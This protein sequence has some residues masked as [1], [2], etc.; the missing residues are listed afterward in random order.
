MRDV[1][2]TLLLANIARSKIDAGSDSEDLRRRLI[3]DL[4]QYHIPFSG[5]ISVVLLASKK[6]AKVITITQ[7]D[8]MLER[9][10]L[11]RN[12]QLVRAA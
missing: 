10:R 2:V 9:E 6:G 3:R 8:I 12:G 5:S 11:A 1:E 7:E 4:D